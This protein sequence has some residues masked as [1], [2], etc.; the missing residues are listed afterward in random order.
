MLIQPRLTDHRLKQLSE[1]LSMIIVHLYNL[2]PEIYKGTIIE[3]QWNRLVIDLQED[4]SIG[5]ML[6]I[7][8]TVQGIKQPKNW[9]EQNDE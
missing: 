7:I 9:H 6:S 5:E 4:F 1:Q 2:S 3:L 8:Q